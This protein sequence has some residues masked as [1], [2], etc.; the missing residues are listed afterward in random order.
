MNANKANRKHTLTRTHLAKTSKLQISTS[1]TFS[2]DIMDYVKILPG[3]KQKTYRNL[4]VI[5]CNT[6]F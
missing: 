1:P 3:M 6:L 4:E 2:L 5:Y